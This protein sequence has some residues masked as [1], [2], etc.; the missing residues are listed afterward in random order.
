MNTSEIKKEYVSTKYV[1]KQE[2]S[3]LNGREAEH[4]K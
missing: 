2:Q 4:N 3:L 1:D